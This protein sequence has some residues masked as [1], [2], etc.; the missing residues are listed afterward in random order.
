M[1]V[2]PVVDKIV[3]H[4]SKYDCIGNSVLKLSLYV[5]CQFWQMILIWKQN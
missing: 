2:I 1:Y 4:L 3:T 5:Q